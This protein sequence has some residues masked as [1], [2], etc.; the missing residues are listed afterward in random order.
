MIGRTKLIESK[1]GI[2]F[3]YS[4]IFL[5]ILKSTKFICRLKKLKNVGKSGGWET[6][7]KWPP[8][9]FS[10]SE[11]LTRIWIYRFRY[12]AIIERFLI[13]KIDVHTPG[14]KKSK[15]IALLLVKNMQKMC[16]FHYLLLVFGARNSKKT[17]KILLNI[18]K[19]SVN[20]F[21]V[22]RPVSAEIAILAYFFS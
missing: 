19:R 5:Y 16:I 20:E 13:F 7:E 22:N 9:R 18:L 4:K 10:R 3:R 2:L 1:C 6:N 12:L 17:L 14:T 21:N 15:K 11:V 8:L